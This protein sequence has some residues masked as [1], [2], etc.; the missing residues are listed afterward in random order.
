[1]VTVQLDECGLTGAITPEIGNLTNLTNLYLSGNYLTSI[2]PEIGNLTNLTNL[3]L[4]GNQLT[5]LPPEIG[6]LTN[7]TNLESRPMTSA[8]DITAP[9]AA[10]RVGASDLVWLS[11]SGSGCPT[12]SDPDVETWVEGFD[13]LWDSAA[14]NG[15]CVGEPRRD[16]LDDR[17]GHRTANR[18]R[19]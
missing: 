14:T 18:V 7:L 3:S 1:M 8:G 13:S 9:T 19:S 15:R 6:N 10:L 17:H 16:L 11:L 12:I 2:P 4:D 5:S